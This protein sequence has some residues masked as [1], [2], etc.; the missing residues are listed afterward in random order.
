MAAAILPASP[1]SA[2]PTG[3]A[4]INGIAGDSITRPDSTTTVINQASPRLAIN[5]TSFSSAEGEKIQFVQKDVSAIALN[6]VTGRTPSELLGT[7]TANGQ[8]FVINPN[9]VLFGSKASVDVGGLVASTLNMDT[10]KFLEGSQALQGG[11]TGSVINRGKLTATE[12]G[13]ASNSGYIALV[14]PRV[15]NEG[16]ITAVQGR[17]LM[18]AGDS[19]TLTLAGRSLAGYTINRG[20]LDALVD[21]RGMISA[22]GGRVTLDARAAD[23]LSQAVVNHTG[24]IEAQ[25]LNRNRGLI[26]LSGG[27]G[28]EDMEAGDMYVAG[29]LDVSAPNG[30]DGGSVKTSAARVNIGKLAQVDL[31]PQEFG[32]NKGTWIN[33]SRDFLIAEGNGPDTTTSIGAATLSE[34]LSSASWN[35]ITPNI[36]TG[37]GDLYVNAP[38]AWGSGKT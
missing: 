15:I 9:G 38:V 31:L 28:S 36:V 2:G 13:T 25:T 21:N 8:V 3:G 30:G 19:V 29:K 12:S 18:A 24:V 23:K 1:V 26:Q 34:N 32:G 6:R 14:G 37:T 16:N 17:V 35:P 22:S 27:I 33:T 5:W 20:N 7:L 10:A 4:I 11:G